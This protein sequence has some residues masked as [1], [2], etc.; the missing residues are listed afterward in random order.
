M[1]YLLG[2]ICFIL[3]TTVVMQYNQKKTL[4]R[5]FMR[6]VKDHR[7]NGDESSDGEDDKE[8]GDDDQ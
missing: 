7:P 5:R 8:I 3:L 6:Y 4:R 1:E 2:I